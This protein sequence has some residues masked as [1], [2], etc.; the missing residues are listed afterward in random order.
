MN[1]KLFEFHDFDKIDF[2]SDPPQKA[3]YDHCNFLNCN[4]YESDISDIIFN[5]CLFE[6][7][8]FSLVRCM[9]AV[10]NDVRFIRCKLLGL[11][12][13]NCN[14]LLL[15]VYF[16]NCFIR[17]SSFY[18]LKLKKTKFIGCNLQEADFTG[19]DLSG[20]LFDNCDLQGAL[21]DN[22]NLERADLYSS[23][24]YS[25]D[26]EKNRLRKARFSRQGIAGLLTKYDLD[27]E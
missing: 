3:E 13:D 16:E 26:P 9:N 15:S 17:I 12:L 21:F 2:T 10:F 20:A 11:H 27:I 6:N 24:Q 22:T 14:P 4:F 23:Y 7:C 19:T 1:T 25:I 5:S 8:D 18:N